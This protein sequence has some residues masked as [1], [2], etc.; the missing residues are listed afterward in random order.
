MLNEMEIGNPNVTEAPEYF[1]N[2]AAPTDVETEQPPG[3]HGKMYSFHFS[4]VF[5]HK[6]KKSDREENRIKNQ[7]IQ[8]PITKK[9]IH[10][11]LLHMVVL[12]SNEYHNFCN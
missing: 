8:N 1:P 12:K 7:N 6:I 11:T 10:M 9:V 5:N 4:Y 3:R 2:V